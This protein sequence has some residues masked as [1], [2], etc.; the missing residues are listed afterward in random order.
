M[1]KGNKQ[2]AQKKGNKKTTTVKSDPEVHT[3]F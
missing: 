2:K 1:Q 3:P